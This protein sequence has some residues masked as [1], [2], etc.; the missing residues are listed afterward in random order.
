M[1]LAPAILFGVIEG[2]RFILGLGLLCSVF[3]L[4]YIGLVVWFQ[5][6][7]DGMTSDQIPMPVSASA[8][9]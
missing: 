5:K 9:N 4:I 6:K 2:S 8:A 1:T 7:P 3:D